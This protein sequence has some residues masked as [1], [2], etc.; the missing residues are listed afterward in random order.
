MY[1]KKEKRSRIYVQRK[2][3]RERQSIKEEVYQKKITRKEEVE[4]ED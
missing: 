4:G 3:K 2:R 1:G